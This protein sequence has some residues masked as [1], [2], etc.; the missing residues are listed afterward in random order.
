MPHG[1][2]FAVDCENYFDGVSKC[3]YLRGAVYAPQMASTFGSMAIISYR[4]MRADTLPM[5]HPSTL[6]EGNVYEAHRIPIAVSLRLV[7]AAY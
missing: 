7:V 6:L 4:T 1:L 5:F 3:P 2:R